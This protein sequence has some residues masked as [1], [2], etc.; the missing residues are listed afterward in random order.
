MNFL[1][2]I[3]ITHYLESR[4][5]RPLNFVQLPKKIVLYN[6]NFPVILQRDT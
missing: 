4:D 2:S 6:R 1:F 5:V 3:S